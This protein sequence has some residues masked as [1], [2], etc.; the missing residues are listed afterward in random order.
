MQENVLL[1]ILVSSLATY[2]FRF[3]GVLCSKKLKIDSWIFD[4]IRCISVGIIVAVISKI[5]FF[6]EGILDKTSDSSRY[7]STILLIIIFYT[8]KKNILLSVTLSTIF[9]TIINYYEIS[10]F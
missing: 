7:L 3:L 9:F 10:L 1:A 5:I 4:W 6:P 8:S 2:F